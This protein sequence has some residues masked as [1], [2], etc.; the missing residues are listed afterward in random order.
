MLL[1]SNDTE[2]NVSSLAPPSFLVHTKLL[3]S[4]NWMNAS[5]LPTLPIAISPPSVKIEDDVV[6][7]TGTTTSNPSKIFEYL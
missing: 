4:N 7:L 5:L 3:F 2:K 6:V 1:L